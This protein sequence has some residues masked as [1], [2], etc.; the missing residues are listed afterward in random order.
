MDK[1]GE[2]NTLRQGPSVFIS[3]TTAGLRHLR[4]AAREGIERAGCRAVVME[5]FGSVPDYPDSVCQQRL[6]ECD[7]YVGILGWRYGS[8]PPGSNLSY[9]EREYR[10]AG[11]RGLPRL[12]FLLDQELCED[13]LSHEPREPQILRHKQECFRDLARA[14]KTVP[15]ISST[16]DL[17]AQVQ[18]SVEACLRNE[19]WGV[20][21]LVG[22]YDTLK[23]LRAELIDDH[24]NLALVGHPGSGKSALYQGLTKWLQRQSTV[25]TDGVRVWAQALPEGGPSGLGMSGL[26]PKDLAPLCLTALGADQPKQA[27]TIGELAGLLG[28]RLVDN[29]PTLVALDNVWPSHLEGLR[30]LCSAFLCHQNVSV[31]MTTTFPDLPRE[32]SRNL[33]R[34]FYTRALE[35]LT[36]DAALQLITWDVA[37]ELGRANARARPDLSALEEVLRPLARYCGGYPQVLRLFAG[38]VASGGSSLQHLG[39]RAESIEV[40]LR[41]H[42]W[43]EGGSVHA[44]AELS[45]LYELVLGRW[46]APGGLAGPARDVLAVCT[47]LPPMPANYYF[48][49]LLLHWKA[50]VEGPVLGGEDARRD[51]PDLY[52]PGRM[53]TRRSQRPF[54]DQVTGLCRQQLL[55][56]AGTKPVGREPRGDDEA[57]APTQ[58]CYGHHAVVGDYFSR[59]LWGNEAR[60]AFHRAAEAAVRGQ[61]EDGPLASFSGMFALESTRWQ[62]RIALWLFHLAHIGSVEPAEARFRLAGLYLDAFWWWGYNLEYPFCRQLIESWERV[63]VDDEVIEDH[64]DFVHHLYTVEDRYPRGWDRAGSNM[65]PV[66]QALRAIAPLID[67]DLQAPIEGFASKDRLHVYGLL[68]VFL[69][70]CA[71]FS[72]PTKPIPDANFAEARGHYETALSAFVRVG[73]HFGSH[74]DEWNE[75]WVTYELA[76]LHLAHGDLARAEELC[77]KAEDREHGRVEAARL[78]NEERAK[79]GE[80][81]DEDEYVLEET[82]ANVA[83]VRADIAQWRGSVAAGQG[84]AA[85]ARAQ[86]EREA[87]DRA[88]AV[89]HAFA[90]QVRPPQTTPSKRRPGHFDGGPDAYTTS[91]YIEMCERAAR[92]VMQLME[93]ERPDHAAFM[94]R[95]LACRW[96]RELSPRCIAL[97]DKVA[98]GNADAVSVKLL[99]EALF[100]APFVQQAYDDTRV[101][102]DYVSSAL[103]LVKRFED[104]KDGESGESS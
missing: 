80:E 93:Q 60:T 21:D 65:E 26:G 58:A 50:A 96:A 73:E 64:L 8:C 12:V 72:S 84:L 55:T 32:L 6:D 49:T 1:K 56:N 101:L 77:Q 17:V 88:L 40:E 61:L 63:Q 87:E 41:E 20:H 14:G 90:F 23:V 71:Y 10:Y 28:A 3:S 24:A 75:S 36:E 54:F 29:R 82:L 42:G 48:D 5:E 52:D 92:R 16:E 18:R 38:L 25:V 43:V 44:R 94:A 83:S 76:E 67:V 102:D 62:E 33:P 4:E 100:P 79:A 15:R 37:Q 85:Q 27:A 74:A 13:E 98:S 30:T 66:R 103:K 46:L 35:P 91:F 86:L 57:H 45:A 19:P 95:A 81:A 2:V 53:G 34:G 69:A 89:F 11:M 104:K 7:V 97:L 39:R 70:H 31:L 78:R 68:H 59:T 9:T 22:R 99:V 47:L 51:L